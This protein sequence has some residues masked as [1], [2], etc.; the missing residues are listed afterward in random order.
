MES[1]NYDN[2]NSYKVTQS[3]EQEP[4]YFDMSMR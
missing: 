3:F 1:K 2:D 4:D